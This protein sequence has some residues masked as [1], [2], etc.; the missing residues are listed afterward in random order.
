MR[1]PTG[2]NMQQAH[3]QMVKK[4]VKAYTHRLRHPDIQLICYSGL[5]PCNSREGASSTGRVEVLQFPH[6]DTPERWY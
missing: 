3:V 4:V 1:K 2:N 6:I 5:L